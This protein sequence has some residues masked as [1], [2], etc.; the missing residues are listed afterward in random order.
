VEHG[1]GRIFQPKK[2]KKKASLI[3]TVPPDEKDS[4]RAEAS[5]RGV[6]VSTYLRT[7][8]REA[9][10]EAAR[11]YVESMKVGGWRALYEQTQVFG[12]LGKEAAERRLG[13]PLLEEE[14][15]AVADEAYRL[16]KEEEKRF[17]Q[18]ASLMRKQWKGFR[19]PKKG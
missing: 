14:E 15:K 19:P 17:L 6:T 16:A 9:D 5:A 4:I 12:F 2:R 18:E 7:L 1:D 10:R 3:I 11:R 13:R 8:H